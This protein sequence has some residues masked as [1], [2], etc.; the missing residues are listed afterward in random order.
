M[1]AGL[2]R[3]R[4]RVAG[5]T[6]SDTG[7]ACGP[8]V[9]VSTK[10]SSG[11]LQRRRVPLHWP[12]GQSLRI[13]A[14]DGGGI[15]GI[16]PATFLAGLERRFLGG[17]SIAEYFDMI[18]G[19]S[20]GAIIALGL[21]SGFKSADIGRLYTERGCEIF[22]PIGDSGIGCLRRGWQRVSQ[23]FKFR[24][25]R[26]ALLIVLQDLFGNRRLGD[27]ITRLCIPSF[28]GRHG[29]PYVFKTPH[30]PDYRLDRHEPMVK[31]AAATSA[32]PAF[33]APLEDGGYKFVDGGVWCNNPV[34]VALVDVL[35]CFDVRRDDISILSIGCGTRP[36]TVGKFKIRMGGILSWQDIIY[37][38][39]RLQSHNAV[40]QA[41]LLIGRDQIVRVD[42]PAKAHRIG[43]DDWTR[44]VAMLP[45]AA[46]T[47]LEKHGDGV[48]SAFLRERATVYKP[49]PVLDD[50]VRIPNQRT[51][52]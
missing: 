14:I 51:K 13:L 32:A 10:R 5:D 21:A 33:Y 2:L 36:Y 8:C 25:E 28:D 20:T 27:S 39:M 30:H 17:D 43:L 23:F 45:A 19:T 9:G 7:E 18:T 38:A 12:E 3:V 4:G 37:A 49:V 47:A 52:E 35:A 44:A 22:P 40:G 15:R 41:G 29:E 34:M 6:L 46:E 31:V 42:A 48:A 16:F 26:R 11:T 50:T 24:Y 1:K